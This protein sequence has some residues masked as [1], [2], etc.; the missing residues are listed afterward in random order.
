[1]MLRKTFI[2]VIVALALLLSMTLQAGACVSSGTFAQPAGLYPAYT[3]YASSVP[4]YGTSSYVS[5]GCPGCPGCPDNPVR[6]PA[7]P[8]CY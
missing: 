3:T 4:Q 8:G 2:V 6:D 5:L 7:K 1:M